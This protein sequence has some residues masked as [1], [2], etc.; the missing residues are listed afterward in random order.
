V[1][2]LSVGGTGCITG[3]A[4]LY[5]RVCV[6]IFDKY[7]AGKLAEAKR[8]QLELGKMEIGFGDGGI[9]GTKWV[10]GELLGYPAGSRDCRRPY[11]RFTDKARQQWIL[12]TVTVLEPEEA[13]LR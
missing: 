4:N 6:A 5:P 3:V 7:V 10:C 11:P 8:L 1:P 9:N 13:R 2:A 12:D